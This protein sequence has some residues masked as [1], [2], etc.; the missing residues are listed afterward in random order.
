M[1]KLEKHSFYSFLGLYVFSSFVLIS[2][3]GYW[4]FVS[5][6][7]MLTSKVHYEMEHAIDQEASRIIYAHMQHGRYQY[8]PPMGEI[9][10]SLIDLGGKVLYGRAVD[11]L[12]SLASGFYEDGEVT[13]LVSDA[14]KGHLG[15]ALIVAQ[16]KNLSGEIRMLKQHILGVLL[17]VMLAVAVIAWM[18]SRIFMRP[19]RQ[20]VLQIETFINDVTHELNTP[21]TALG[22]ATDQAARSGLCPDKVLNHISISTKQL[23]DIYRSLSYLNFSTEERTDAVTDVAQTLEESLAYYAPLAEIKRIELLA[24]IE[25]CIYPIPEAQLSLLF[26][27]LIGNAI[28]YSPARSTIRLSLSEGTFIISDEGIGIKKE[29]Q[30][31]VFEKFKRGTS[32]SGGFGV[33]LSVVRS[34]CQRYGIEIALDSDEGKG[35]RFTLHFINK[36]NI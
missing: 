22:M 13:I 5:Q 26:G 1:T 35:V 8:T 33:G 15:I 12:Q 29:Q 10:L 24:D 28:K 9:T 6:S 20:R 32:Q 19:L 4:Y 18:L 25:H 36:H 34:I 27:N 2:L 7:Q 30:R 16:T 31:E 14:P 23:H 11:G 3:V 21:I 17:L